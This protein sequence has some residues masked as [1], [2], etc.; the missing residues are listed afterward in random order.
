MDPIVALRQ[1]IRLAPGKRVRVAFWTLVAHSKTELLLNIE[2]HNER[3]AYG[4][5]AM[6]AWTQ[7]QVQLRH[8]AVTV[9]EAADFSAFDRSL[10][11]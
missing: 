2:Q 8:L 7:A 1:S 3:S 4:R 11:V 5:A 9:A 6:L 10:I